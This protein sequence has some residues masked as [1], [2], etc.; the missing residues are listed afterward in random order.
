MINP[1]QGRHDSILG[2]EGESEMLREVARDIKNRA[3]GSELD[4][5]IIEYSLTVIKQD[6]PEVMA[7]H[8]VANVVYAHANPESGKICALIGEKPEEGVIASNNKILVFTISGNNHRIAECTGKEAFSQRAA[9]NIDII[10]RDYNFSVAEAE[11]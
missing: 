6:M 8:P 2:P 10:I 3:E 5:K 9:A 11:E 4:E 1:E 7:E